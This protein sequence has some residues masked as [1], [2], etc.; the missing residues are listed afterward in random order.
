V[1]LPTEQEIKTIME[2]YANSG[3]YT[4]TQ[5]QAMEEA[6][7]GSP[8]LGPKPSELGPA[9]TPSAPTVPDNLK[10]MIPE[11]LYD[12]TDP[13]RRQVVEKD[14]EGDPIRIRSEYLGT[15]YDK[16][17]GANV[18][19]THWTTEATTPIVKDTTTKPNA[20]SWE[21]IDKA[22]TGW[23]DRANKYYRD[24]S[25]AWQ[26]AHPG[27]QITSD[28]ANSWVKQ[29]ELQAT[30]EAEHAGLPGFD[31]KSDYADKVAQLEKAMGRPLTEAEKMK[32]LGLGG[33]GG[34]GSVYTQFQ[35]EQIANERMRI[36]IEQQ[37]ANLEGDKY[38]FGLATSPM[39]YP[40]YW[41]YT[42]P[43]M[44]PP[45]LGGTPIWAGAPG[46]APIQRVGPLAPG[47]DPYAGAPVA[48]P[49]GGAPVAA[50]V[51]A[52]ASPETLTDA[53]GAPVGGAP[54][55]PPV[56]QAVGDA[57][58]APMPAVLQQ[59]MTGVPVS[60]MAQLPPGTIPVPGVQAQGNMMPSE[61]AM[62]TGTAM[63]QGIPQQDWEWKMN[64][65]RQ[66]AGKPVAQAGFGGASVVRKA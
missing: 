16:E 66:A 34:G 2:Y 33:S 36:A 6:M 51:A 31:A 9:G 27:E 10:K 15:H 35:Q 22:R 12:P 57:S 25:N 18:D 37:R 50:P 28:L 58:A 40:L 13:R 39:D 11:I 45:G 49:V 8:Q 42:H 38:K 60:N 65:A 7:R 43:G 3:R 52:P 53:V 32:V 59:M 56:E 46:V 23:Q 14:R 61:L 29:G 41:N 54:V 19:D 26:A 55:A 21:E 48:A 20:K 24:A 17:S 47:L 30:Q 63:M 5:L 4:A 64:L 62:L 44:A 1:P